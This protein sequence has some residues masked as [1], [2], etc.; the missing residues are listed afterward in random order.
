MI[1]LKKDSL[2]INERSADTIHVLLITQ[3]YLSVMFQNTEVSWKHFS[4]IAAMPEYGRL[5]ISLLL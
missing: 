5:R 4:S 3:Q 2:A 1:M